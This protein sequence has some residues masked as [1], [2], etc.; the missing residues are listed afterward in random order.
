MKYSMCPKCN[1]V[2]ASLSDRIFG[3]WWAVINTNKV[4]THCSQALV[5]NLKSISMYFLV[6]IVGIVSLLP[7]WSCLEYSIGLLNHLFPTMG[8]GGG[9]HFCLWVM[10]FLSLNFTVPY[11]YGK[12]YGHSI[13]K[14]KNLEL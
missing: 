3:H 9:I 6:F 7:A 14:I 10:Y 13:Y 12:L 11:A 5:L 8:L 2:P 4:C 1:Q